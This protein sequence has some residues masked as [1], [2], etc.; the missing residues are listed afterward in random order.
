MRQV[1]N[2][3]GTIMSTQIYILDTTL[4]DGQQSPG[5]GM[6]YADNL[7]YSSLAHK[8]KIDILEAGFPSA[9]NTD[10]K[11]VN[12]I[13]KDMAYI[14]SEMKISGLCQLREDQVHKTME[15][16]APSLAINRARIHIYVPV[17]PEL[18]PVSLGNLANDKPLIIETVHK[19]IKVMTSTGFEVEFSPEGYSRMRDNFDFTTDVIRAAVDAGAGIIN[20]PDTIGGASRYEGE[21]YFVNKITLSYNIV[22]LI[23]IYKFKNYFKGL[24]KQMPSK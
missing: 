24:F 23:G 11:I 13:A 20:C 21:N 4:R 12:Q 3:K 18:M 22:V 5:A 2:Y 9:S 8:L 15:A 10:F 17:D 6:S 14:K 19:L 7:H 1:T 16:L